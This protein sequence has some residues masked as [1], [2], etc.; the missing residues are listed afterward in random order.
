MGNPRKANGARRRHVVRWLRSQGRPCWICGLPID[1][2]MPAGDPGPSSAM[3]SSRSAAADRPSTA[4]T[5]L[6]RTAAATTGAAPAASPRSRPSGPRSPRA[7]P[8][9]TRPRRSSR[10]ARRSRTIAP[11]LLVPRPCL[12]NSLGQRPR[13]R[14]C[15]SALDPTGVFCR[16]VA[17]HHP[18]PGPQ[19]PRIRFFTEVKP[20]PQLNRE[21]LDGCVREDTRHRSI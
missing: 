16:M 17:G 20:K 12:T 6:P 5:S 4:T 18:A 2:G 9:G 14:G 21:K 1:Y 13:G 10:C 19:Y 8:P 11:R 15:A 3:S 7:A